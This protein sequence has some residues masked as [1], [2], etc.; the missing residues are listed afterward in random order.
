MCPFLSL[1]VYCF[2]ANGNSWNGGRAILSA[3]QLKLNNYNELG[4]V[5]ALNSVASLREMFRKAKKKED[6]QKPVEK[7]AKLVSLQRDR[8]SL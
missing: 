1:A 2:S 7:K 6:R 8:W 3:A 4:R 5:W